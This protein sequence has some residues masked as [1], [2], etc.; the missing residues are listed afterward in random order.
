M[1]GGIN[2]GAQKAPSR[3]KT[4]T[5]PKSPYPSSPAALYPGRIVYNRNGNKHENNLK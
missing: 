1:F 2:I 4:P 5:R 3:A